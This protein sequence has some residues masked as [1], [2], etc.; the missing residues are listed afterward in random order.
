MHTLTT[1]AAD[2]PGISGG[3]IFGAVTASGAALV[4]G[5]GLILGLKGSDWGPVK[6]E[7][8]K[9]AAWWGIVTG[10]IWVAA[11]GTWAEIAQGIGSVPPSL[12]AGGDFGNPGQ[13]AIA[14]FLTMLAF[15]PRWGSKTAPP[16][17]IGLAAAVVYGTAGGVWGI[18]VNIVRMGVGIITGQGG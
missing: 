10:T 9:K 3:Q 2:A 4:A 7:N 5:T 8:K 18:L 12:F 17:I 14:I 11:G 1:L 13:G 6:I 16:A 15:G